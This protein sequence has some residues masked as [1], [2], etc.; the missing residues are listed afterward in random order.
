MGGVACLTVI[1]VQPNFQGFSSQ[2][3]ALRAGAERIA[4]VGSSDNM[5]YVVG[6]TRAEYLVDVQEL[7]PGASSWS[8][9]GGAAGRFAGGRSLSMV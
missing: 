2:G 1:A 8:W 5:M 3:E 6:A 7:V 9:C 4:G